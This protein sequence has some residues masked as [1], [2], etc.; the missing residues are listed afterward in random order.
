MP[1]ITIPIAGKDPDYL[2]HLEYALTFASEEIISFN[3]DRERLKVEVELASSSE[4]AQES[5]ARSVSELVD[6]FSVQQFGTVQDVRF[7]QE[8]SL[9]IID[10]WAALLERRW[11]TPIGEGHVILRGP[12][13]QLMR[14]ISCKV[15]A[16]ASHFQAE[17]E[18]YPSTIK[19][20]T[21]DR[22]NHFTSFPEHI[23]FVAHIKPDL[24]ALDQFSNECR[25]KGW[26]PNHHEGKMGPSDFAISPSCCY[27]CYEGM[28]GWRLE[29]KGRCVTMTLGCHRY[30]GSRHKSLGRL[31]AFTMQEVV[32]IGN[33][34]YVTESRAKA[35]QLIIQWAKDWELCCSFETANDMF[36]TRD[37]SVKAPF[38]RRQQAKRELLANIP[39]EDIRLALFSSNFHA[40]TFG[41]AFDI[42]A[43]GRTATTGC[44]GWGLERWVYAIF[45]QFGLDPAGWPTKLRKE[46]LNH[47]LE[48]ERAG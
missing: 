21:L 15:D 47:C 39:S 14:L 34:K 8:R 24:E 4:S 37:F 31:R 30:E 19:S 41:K 18:I 13:A 16:F 23:D 2:R 20:K 11:V 32:F 6:R 36:F 48:E 12:A 1:K 28:E 29:D 5:A 26:A 44:V 7:K 33:P 25:D 45:S 40:T 42:L 35:E 27:H 3:I 9:P 46:Y 17:L 43:D 10:A 22:C 38:Q